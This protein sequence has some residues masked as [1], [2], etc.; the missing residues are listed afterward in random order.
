MIWQWDFIFE[1][2]YAKFPEKW[3]IFW[4]FLRDLKPL[5][6][7]YIKEPFKAAKGLG[8]KPL[9]LHHYYHIYSAILPRIMLKDE[10]WL[11]KF[12]KYLRYLKLPSLNLAWFTSLR[13]YCKKCTLIANSILYNYHCCIPKYSWWGCLLDIENLKSFNK[14]LM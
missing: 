8:A 2:R 1:T 4:Q 10:L 13:E 5:Y 6:L 7:K 12:C 14:S 3:R 9:L 11:T